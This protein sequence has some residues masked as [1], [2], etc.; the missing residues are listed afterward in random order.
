L[1]RHF[2]SLYAQRMNKRIDVILPETMDALV[3]Y[4]W[5]GNIRE[6]QNFIERAV[7]LSPQSILRAP[8]FELEPF[9][10][11]KENNFYMNG[12][13]EVMCERPAKRVFR[14]PYEAMG[15]RRSRISRI[16][17]SAPADCG[18][19]GER[20]L[21]GETGS[22]IFVRR[23]SQGAAIDGIEQSERQDH[24]KGVIQNCSDPG[25]QAYLSCPVIKH[26]RKFLV[27][28]HCERDLHQMFEVKEIRK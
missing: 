1:V 24:R 25:E 8:T 11:S 23:S 28:P 16:R 20:H 3:R 14:H 27:L 4:Q 7:I 22:G 19:S 5:P 26:Y 9:Q 21:Q 18:S 12:L 6:L 2:T 17:S 10:T 15:L 13:A